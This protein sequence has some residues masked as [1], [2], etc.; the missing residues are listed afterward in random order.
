MKKINNLVKYELINLKRGK[1]IW[2]IYLLYI[3]GIQQIISSMYNNG[4]F[5]L[6]L[7]GLIQ[8]SWL[9]LNF[10]MI[11]II[12]LSMKIGE[13][14]DDIFK[15]LDISVK[16]IILS[17]FITL[18]VIGLV[19]LTLNLIL[20]ILIAAINTVSTEYFLYNII[21]YITNTVVC[22]IVCNFL[23]LLIGEVF[24]RYAGDVIGFISILIL[25]V[26]LSNFYKLSNTIFPLI[27]IRT[28]PNKFDVISYDKSYLC[29]NTFWLIIALISLQLILMHRHNLKTSLTLIVSIIFCV[30]LTIYMFYTSPQFYDI[31]S[32]TDVIDGNYCNN[33]YNT[34]F[35]K[36]DC[37]YYVDKYNMQLN[38]DDKLENHCSM[39]IKMDKDNINSLE[40]GL[41]EKFKISRLEINNQIIDFNRTNHSFIAKLPNNCKKGEVIKMDVYYSGKVNTIW[42]QGN[43]LFFVRNNWIFLADV[44]EWYPKLNDSKIK[45]FNLN[46]K[47]SGKNKIYSN[48]DGDNK[49]QEWN[50]YGKD[51]EIFLISGNI[52]ERNYRGYLVVGNEEVI[53]DNNQCD[54]TISIIN[55]ENLNGIT[56]IVYSPFI[57]GGGKITKPYEKAYLHPDN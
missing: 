37:G 30:P 57:P 21:G 24:S 41:Y 2:I 52:K 3:F 18:M 9:P 31:H 20:Y 23:G 45:E 48:L 26:V 22:L 8:N 40:L 1:L 33:N 50:F 19:I 51:S 15:T 34:F 47:S 25:F 35:A 4:Q 16:Q 46:I 42:Q 7:V 6:T 55:K 12:L 14:D 56:K 43:Q 11:P 5:S 53:N 10:I 13:S 27:D 17:K 28:F 39:E 54:V 36:N 32:R 29:H 38:I 49:L 44:F